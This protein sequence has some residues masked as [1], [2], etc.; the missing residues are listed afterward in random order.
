MIYPEI[1]T[2]LKA[3]C[4]EFKN[5]RINIDILKSIIWKTSQEII[6]L[7]EKPLRDFLMSS[8]ANIDSFQFTMDSSSLYESIDCLID[9][10]IKEISKY[11]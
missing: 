1:I 7:E 6:A 10:I 11:Y 9:D 2:A 3:A 4:D 5:R 8:E